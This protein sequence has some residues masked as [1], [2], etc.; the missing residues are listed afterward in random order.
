MSSGASAGAPA[1]APSASEGPADGAADGAADSSTAV[2]GPGRYIDWTD[3][4]IAATPGRKALFF[5]AS[6]CPT[7]RKLDADLKAK[8]VPAGLTVIKVDYD[9]HTDL[10]QKY[11][12]TI[13]TTVVFVDDRG[14]KI[15]STVLSGDPSVAGLVAAAP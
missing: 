6:W 4:V 2:T 11:G 9:S 1:P 12:V 7:C 3:G 13:Q 14:Q 8:G 10:R 15:S 5:H